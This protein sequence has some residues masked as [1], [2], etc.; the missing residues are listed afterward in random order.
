MRRWNP[1]EPA[2]GEFQFAAHDDNGKSSRGGFPVLS[3]DLNLS[4]NH[5]KPR[6][7]SRLLKRTMV[8]KNGQRITP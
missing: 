4:G 2:G 3:R 6:G 7:N 1:T 5:Q 8:E